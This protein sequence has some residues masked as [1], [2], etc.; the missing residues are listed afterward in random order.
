M[1]TK[2][3]TPLHATGYS[4]GELLRRADAYPQLVEALRDDLLAL[5]ALAAMIHNAEG[6]YPLLEKRRATLRS[7]GEEA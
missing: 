4:K 3:A 5:E 1:N 2:P 6:T 7:I